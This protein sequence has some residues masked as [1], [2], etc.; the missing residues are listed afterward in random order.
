M[1][2]N[3]SHEKLWAMLAAE[4]KVSNETIQNKIAHHLEYTLGKHK[5]NTTEED[6]YKATSYAVRD[7]I[8]DRFND[9]QETYRKKNP[10]RV[11]YLSL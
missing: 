2:I 3:N 7:V 5:F 9:T 8:I 1:V 4:R 6:V 11:Y 10:K